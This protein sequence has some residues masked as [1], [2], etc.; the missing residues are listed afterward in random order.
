[1]KKIA[2]CI[3]VM[4]VVLGA[5]T[6]SAAAQTRQIA[7]QAGKVAAEE[8]AV[9]RQI[10]Q[11]VSKACGEGFNPALGVLGFD[12]CP[13]DP[14]FGL[15]NYNPVLG[16]KTPLSEEVLDVN[17]QDALLRADYPIQI[18]PQTARTLSADELFTPLDQATLPQLTQYIYM[19]RLANPGVELLNTSTLYRAARKKIAQ[20]TT[21]PD[22]RVQ[23]IEDVEN[24]PNIIFLVRLLQPDFTPKTYAQLALETKVYPKYVT[25]SKDSFPVL[26]TQAAQAM[27]L[28]N[29]LLLSHP[30]V[31][32]MYN[33]G[34]VQLSRGN[35]YT[36]LVLTR[37][38]RLAA[39]QLLALRQQAYRLPEN[40]TIRQVLEVAYNHLESHTIPYNYWHPGVRQPSMYQPYPNYVNNALYKKVHQLMDQADP[41]LRESTDLSHLIV[42]DAVMGGLGPCWQDVY[43]INR[44]LDA[45][46][47]LCKET[48][49]TAG[50]LAH[51]QQ[52]H[53]SLVY[54]S[55]VWEYDARN[56]LDR[57]E[58]DQLSDAELVLLQERVARFIK[59]DVAK[60]MRGK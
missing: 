41:V 38:E 10:E 53:K 12:K 13:A 17:N 3:P 40:P 47:K 43:A 7:R 32:G 45:F 20:D 9:L 2:L 16:Y 46:E 55:G 30:H 4:G 6:V 52:L 59:L 22:G 24:T 29:Y 42:L 28:D 5:L 57:A 58:Y 23:A 25:L 44:A 51:L 49:F 34:N 33:S 37:E 56:M 50:N 1:M 11:T 14:M 54:A 60:F 8:S 39:E 26:T 19:W 36:G 48:P 27:I 31:M 21:H 15:T 35:Y 18:A